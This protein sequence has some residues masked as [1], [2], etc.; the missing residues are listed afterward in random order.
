MTFGIKVGEDSVWRRYDLLANERG[1]RAQRAAKGAMR[2]AREEMLDRGR[3]DIEA[4]GNFGRRWTQGLKARVEDDEKGTTLTVT[5]DVPY[6]T[7]HQYGKRITGKPLL[8]IPL[9]GTDAERRRIWARDYPGGLFRVDREGKA[10]LLL[11]LRTGEPKYFL[12]RQVYVP[13]RFHIVEIARDVARKIR[14]FYVERLR[15]E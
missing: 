5:H 12:K 14:K 11:S 3:R 9:S 1:R 15:G 4:A 2:D 13:K 6:W 7:V 8:A 10:S